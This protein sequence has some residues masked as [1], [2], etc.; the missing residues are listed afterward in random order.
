[1]DPSAQRLRLLLECRGVVQGVGFRPAVHRLARRLGLD[2]SLHNGC[3][4]LRL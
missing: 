1:M 3:G 4:Q 2:G